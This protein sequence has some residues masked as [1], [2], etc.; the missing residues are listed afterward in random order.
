MSSHDLIATV[1]GLAILNEENQ[2]RGGRENLRTS[3]LACTDD[4]NIWHCVFFLI[5]FF[6]KLVPRVTDL[7]GIY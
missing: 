2:H 5:F 7:R 1:K 3:A 6:T 4:R